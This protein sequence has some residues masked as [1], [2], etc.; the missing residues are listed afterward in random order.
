MQEEREQQEQTEDVEAHVRAKG[1]T[2]EPADDPGFRS[3]VEDADDV[4]AHMKIKG[5]PPA[6]EKRAI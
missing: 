5:S 3:R 6:P 1:R 2:E 4:E